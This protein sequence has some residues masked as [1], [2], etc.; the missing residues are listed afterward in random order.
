MSYHKQL[1]SFNE[2]KIPYRLNVLFSQGANE[3]TNPVRLIFQLGL[4]L[5]QVAKRI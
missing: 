2:I 1:Q 5:D 4:K 3:S